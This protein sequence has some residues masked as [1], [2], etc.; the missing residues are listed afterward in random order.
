[1]A[2][3]IAPK[4]SDIIALSLA[5]LQKQLQSLHVRLDAPTTQNVRNIEPCHVTIISCLP[6]RQ[7]DA[8]TVEELWALFQERGGMVTRSSFNTVLSKMAKNCIRTIRFNNAPYQH[9][10]FTI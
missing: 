4:T 5:Q 9:Y 10:Y 8:I 6:T 7:C 3:R 1:M 2:K